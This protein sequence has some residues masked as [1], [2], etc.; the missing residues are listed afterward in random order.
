[1]MRAPVAV[2]PEEAG[3]KLTSFLARR[4][5]RDVPQSVL[6]RWIRTGQ[7]RVDGRRAK[8]FQRLHAGQEV[9]L[10]PQAFAEAEAKALQEPTQAGGLN[11]LL[12]EPD[13]LAL[14][15]PPGL[16]V[17]GGSGHADSVRARLLGMFP[18]AGFAP[19]PV[20]RLD[21]DTSG[22]LLVALSYARL[23]EMQE[24]FKAGSV[25][26]E[27]LAWVAGAWPWSEEFVMHDRLAKI[28]P[29]GRQ[30]MATDVAGKE[31]RA[32]VRPLRVEERASL[33][34]LRLETGRTHQ[35]RVQLAKRGFPILGDLK[36]G[37]P[38]CEQGLLLHCLRLEVFGK[39]IGVPPPWSGAYA[40]G[41]EQ[42]EATV[43]QQ[44]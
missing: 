16:P 23:R 8:P 33:L 4:V 40:P 14:A 32:R 38:P 25:G 18:E 19:T 42:V 31:S 22:V 29:K 41:L 34:L 30:R 10:P 44:P 43:S 26:K 37:A 27:Y 7:V 36:Y 2:T 5:G 28:G 9:R 15:K 35:L 11:I 39:S 21:R 6:M 12:L 24:L 17:H 3:Q 1:M 13:Y 20:H